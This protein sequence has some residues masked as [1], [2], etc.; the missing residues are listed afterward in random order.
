MD[1]KG[2]KLAEKPE[3]FT[4]ERMLA[5]I[6]RHHY[7]LQYLIY[8]VALRRH[9][10]F[11][12]IN[13]P[14]EKI[15]GAIYAFIRGIRRSDESPYGVFVTRPP[16]ALITCLDDFFENGYHEG[17]VVAHAAAAQTEKEEK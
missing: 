4:S 2:T 8:L 10:M 11:C 3:D 12:G 6:N 7:S 16:L 17:V 15:G 1:W 14:E 13:S 5:E 9:L